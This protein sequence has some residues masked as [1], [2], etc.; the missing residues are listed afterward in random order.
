[1]IIRFVILETV[2][3]LIE[4]TFVDFEDRGFPER[5]LRRDLHK[6]AR[7]LVDAFF[8]ACTALLPRFASEPVEHDRFLAA[9][10]AAQHI[11][12]FDR[13]EELVA[14]LVFELHAIV[15]GFADSNRFEAEIL[16]DAMFS[17]NNQIAHAE[18]LQLG[19]ECVGILALLFAANKPVA[20]DV[21]LGEQFHFVVGETCFHRQDRGRRL[22]LGR[23]T[24]RFLPG[25]RH[26][27]RH[28][29]LFEDG[30]YA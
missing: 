6:L 7:N 4:G 29:S 15:F 18:R 23:Q 19:E 26:L 9:A 2:K 20:E 13:D 11:D 10:I 14:A 28:A 8:Q 21:L 1:M 24:Q 16:A 25:F 22:A 30:R 12:I 17:M 27:D 5:A 3:E